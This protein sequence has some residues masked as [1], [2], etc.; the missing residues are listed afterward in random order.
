MGRGLEK[1]PLGRT[2]LESTFVGFGALEIGRDWGLGDAGERQRPDDGEAGRVL[3]SVLDLGL[4]L[5]DSAAAYHRSEERIGTHLSGR[6]AE[7][8]LATKCGEHNREPDTYYD[9]SYGAIKRSIDESLKKLRT[10]VIDLMQIHFGPDPRKVLDD[11]ETVKAMKDARAEGK[12]RFLGAS[13]GGEIAL[14]CIASG[15]FDV[16]QLEYSLT[17]RRDEG[18]V[19]LCG[20]RGIGVLVRGGLAYGR[21]TARVIPHLESLNEGER[22]GTKALLELVGGD[23]R[24]L[25]SL[26]LQFLYRNPHVSS[27]L[28]GSRRAEHVEANI[29]LVDLDLGAGTL[30]KAV[31]ISSTAFLV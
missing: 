8:V 1:R 9:F 27:V 5:V 6:R 15:D 10:D 31:E 12:I 23:G 28:A 19:R 30:E 26:A 13:T 22:A 2:G 24:K 18:I 4:S 20:E 11:G 14:R 7:Y 21:L 29:G 3:N 16:L 17:N 25:T